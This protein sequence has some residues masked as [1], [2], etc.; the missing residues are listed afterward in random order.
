VRVERERGLEVLAG[1][2]R[3][4]QLRLEQPGQRVMCLVRGDWRSA[5]A[6]VTGPASS[7]ACW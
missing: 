4:S 7:M 1:A 3:L 2:H 5:G 6:G